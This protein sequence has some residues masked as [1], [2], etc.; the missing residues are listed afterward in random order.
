LSSKRE[1]QASDSSGE[2]PEAMDTSLPTYFE[3]GMFKN[4]DMGVAPTEFFTGVEEVVIQDVV[5]E[6]ETSMELP[7]STT[8]TVTSAHKKHH[9]H[10]H[11]KAKKKKEKKK[12]HKHR[13]KHRHDHK[14]KSK[15]EVMSSGSSASNSP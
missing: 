6:T 7:E 11:A 9:H 3:P 14:K 5:E 8:S 2:L 4:D 1:S 12:R 15:D 13:H 10:H